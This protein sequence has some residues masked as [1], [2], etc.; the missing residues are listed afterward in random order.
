VARVCGLPFL[1]GPSRRYA[2]VF[3][4]ARWGR[5]TPSQSRGEHY[6]GVLRGWEL[7]QRFAIGGGCRTD[8][9][10]PL[11]RHQTGLRN[12][13]CHCLLMNRLIRL[14]SRGEEVVQE[15]PGSAVEVIPVM[16]LGCCR[17]HKRGVLLAGIM[18]TTAVLWVMGY[19]VRRL[20]GAGNKV[21]DR[22]R[23]RCTYQP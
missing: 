12:T 15:R 21:L 18:E 17:G 20:R 3:G 6:E 9:E 4:V 11:G 7:P 23:V 5:G 8:I 14:R 1:F 2:G 13:S 16:D 19:Q 10:C 22:P